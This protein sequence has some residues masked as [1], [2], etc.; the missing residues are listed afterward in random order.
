MSERPRQPS[1]LTAHQR[2]AAVAAIAE[3]RRDRPFLLIGP[4]GTGKTTT[5][6]AVIARLRSAG[7]RIAATAP[8]HAAA[9]VLG[10][11]LRAA[12]IE[13]PCGTIHSLLG[14][15]PSADDA[16]RRLRQTGENRAIGY[17]VVAID[18]VSMVGRDLQRAIDAGCPRA[19]LFLGDR[20]QLPPVME[21]EAP[22]FA[23]DIGRTELTE[24]VRQTEG[25]PIIGA[26]TLLREQQGGDLDFAWAIENHDGARGI[27]TPAGA[28]ALANLRD[29][30]GPT[31][32]ADPDS[33][34]VLAFTNRAVAGYNALIRRWRYGHTETPFVPGERVVCRRPVTRWANN[35]RGNWVRE[36]L[37]HTLQEATVTRIEDGVEGFNFDDLPEEPKADGEGTWIALDGWSATI[38][39]WHVWLRHQALGA[40]RVVMPRRPADARTIDARLIT[41][42]RL[43]RR[44]WRARYSFL[45]K[46]ADLRAPYAMTVH[47]SQGATYGRVFVDFADLANA[48]G[49]ALFRQ[50][51]A[52]TAVTRP[53]DA[54]ILLRRHHEDGCPLSA[55]L[56]AQTIDQGADCDPIEIDAP[57]LPELTAAPNPARDE[58]KALHAAAARL[59]P[60][61]QQ[62][63]AS[64]A[65]RREISP[66]QAAIVTRIAAER[67]LAREIA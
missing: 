5:A 37:F 10:R 19:V 13:V 48:K 60:W 27:F 34:R 12:G 17:D 32:T 11:K 61:E 21:H 38:P 7:F 51:L 39:V 3:L 1:Q 26:A 24:I 53:S 58:I 15:S 28:D 23:R 33:A 30:F 67:L 57:P 44:R 63:V 18:E 45:E 59:S 36:A 29:A 22:V 41:E 46:I 25:N 35:E 65:S 9:K 66:R 8:T 47:C 54:A 64:L 55:A 52:Y 16:V 50:R 56:A 49:A 14:L 40:V 6:S 31:W 4:A 2:A 62:F 42:A 43:N 20:A